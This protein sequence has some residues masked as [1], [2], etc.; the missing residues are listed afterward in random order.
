MLKRNRKKKI[1]HFIRDID[2]VK[3]VKLENV[4]Y[5]WHK[6]IKNYTFLNDHSLLKKGMYVKYV[7][8]LNN[9]IASGIV[10]S[11]E[12]KNNHIRL[13]TL[14]S[15]QLKYFWKVKPSKNY[16]F[17]TKIKPPKNKFKEWLET[18]I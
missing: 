1:T 7:P 10:T 2:T 12:I 18:F 11:I 13:I 6:R 17:Y 14:K 16:I 15:P 5:K 3:P 8:F 9:K 4:E